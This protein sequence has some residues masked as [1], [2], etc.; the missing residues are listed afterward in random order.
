MRT[1]TNK[2]NPV[3]VVLTVLNVIAGIVLVLI[4]IGM[5]VK[6]KEA[7]EYDP[8][9]FDEEVIR[10]ELED[11][12]YSRVVEKVFHNDPYVILSADSGDDLKAAAVYI[13]A[14]VHYEAYVHADDPENPI[15]YVYKNLLF[16]TESYLDE[17][18]YGKI[19]ARLMNLLE[20]GTD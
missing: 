10:Y 4:M 1:S 7:R 16:E 12:E 15:T 19:R 2:T 3:G 11:G 20:P 14:C 6:L 17:E 9:V 18:I 8:Y 5:F 13:D